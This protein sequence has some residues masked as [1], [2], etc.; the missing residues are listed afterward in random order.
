MNGFAKGV[1]G[2]VVASLLAWGA[3]H[4]TGEDYINGLE[5]K[6]KEALAGEGMDGISLEMKRDPLE[7]LALLDGTDDPEQRKA[8]EAALAAKGITRVKWAGDDDAA[9]APVEGA[10]EEVVANCQ[11]ELD[12]IKE[13]KTVT[14]RSGSAYMGED[15]LGLIGELADKLNACE[16]TNVA[17]G[18]HTDATGSDEVNQNLSQARADAVAAALAER[19]VDASRVTATGFGSSQLKVEGDGA[20]EANRRIEFTLS[21]SGSDAG[22]EEGE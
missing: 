15:S 9:A 5:A 21:S 14:F 11:A 16:G 20:N 18:G 13:G 10:S 22:S 6:G 4:M 8:V 7:R 17:V 12:A 2:A 19:G 3:H 1:T